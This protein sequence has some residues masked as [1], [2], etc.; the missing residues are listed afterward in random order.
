M[1][2]DG[3][4]EEVGLIGIVGKEVTFADVLEEIAL[5]GVFSSDFSGRLVKR[6]GI[7]VGVNED[8]EFRFHVGEVEAE[9]LRR[10]V[11]VGELVIVGGDV[12]ADVDGGGGGGGVA[13]GVGGEVDEGE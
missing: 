10:V 4:E 11:D 1:A 2:G 3:D 13:E 6:V 12:G 9:D 8:L 7:A 5:A